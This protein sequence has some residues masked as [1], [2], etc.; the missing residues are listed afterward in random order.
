MKL[1]PTLLSSLLLTAAVPLPSLSSLLNTVNHVKLDLLQLLA[2]PRNPSPA[3][4]QTGTVVP[5]TAMPA[6][7]TTR[8]THLSGGRYLTYLPIVPPT[9]SSLML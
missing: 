7:T 5:T 2:G 9:S 1:L 6:H 4:S 3:F 8:Y